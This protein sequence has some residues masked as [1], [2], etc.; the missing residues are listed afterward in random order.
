LIGLPDGTRKDIYSYVVPNFDKA[1]YL[2]SKENAYFLIDYIAKNT[3][4]N[5]DEIQTSD[6]VD[7]MK[8]QDSSSL[9]ALMIF[10]HYV[11]LERQYSRMN[12]LEK[13]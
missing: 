9:K 5:K 7:I 4:A 3:L 10:A 12:D 13:S 8:K 2:L 6:L 1:G 11:E